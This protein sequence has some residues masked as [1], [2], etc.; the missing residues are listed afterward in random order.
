MIRTAILVLIGIQ[1]ASCSHGQKRDCDLIA[2]LTQYAATLSERYV[3]LAVPNQIHSASGL[4]IAHNTTLQFKV[5]R[6]GAIWT[7]VHQ[8][9]SDSLGIFSIHIPVSVVNT[10]VDWFEKKLGIV[11][12]HHEDISNSELTLSCDVRFEIKNSVLYT[13]L[14]NNFRWNRKPTLNIAGIEISI[15][16]LAGEQVQKALNNANKSWQYALEPALQSFVNGNCKWKEALDYTFEMLKNYPVG[17]TEQE[18]LQ[19]KVREWID[20]KL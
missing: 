3:N 12:R 10:R 20:L 1:L 15:G 16:T 14:N 13:S 6:K 4:P 9:T 8:S 18:Y 7:S 17:T 19:T 2:T 11:F 5:I